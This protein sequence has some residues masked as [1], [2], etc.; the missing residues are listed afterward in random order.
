V[1]HLLAHRL[2]VP[3]QLATDAQIEAFAVN[4]RNAW[5]E[6]TVELPGSDAEQAVMAAARVVIAN[7]LVGDAA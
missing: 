2:P 7:I 5:V 6:G 1:A 3:D 4:A